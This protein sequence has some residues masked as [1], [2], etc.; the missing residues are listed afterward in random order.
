MSETVIDSSNFAEHFFDAR[1]HR[2]QA[3]QIMAK[4]SAVAYFGEGSEKQD[5]I[6]VLKMGKAQQ[7]AMVMQK[8]H[9]AKEPDCY[10]VC[11]EICEDLVSGMFEQDVLKK[12]Y[13]YVLEA[14]YYTKR[15]NV[16]T[17]DPHWSTID[18]IKFDHETNTF[19]T[20]ITV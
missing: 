12:D 17:D 7:A 20:K 8:I 9:C 11:R 16:P 10:R 6:K 19:K 15:E 13:Q 5:L 3:G 4:F 1:R 18:L 2:P 14:F